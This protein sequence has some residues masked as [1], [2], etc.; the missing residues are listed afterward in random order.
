MTMSRTA[1]EP[2]PPS[3]QC[4]FTVGHDRNGRWLVCDRLG[5]VGGLFTDRASALHFAMEE[6]N[7]EPDQIY[8]V[9]DDKDLSADAVFEAKAATEQHTWSSR[10]A[11]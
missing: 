8:C 4:R 6:S 5:R 3:R 1:K 11:A 9:P 7:R 2:Y 10:R